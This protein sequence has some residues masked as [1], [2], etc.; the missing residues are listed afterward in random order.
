MS[1][2]DPIIITPDREFLVINALRYARG[3][4]TYVAEE[5]C[6]FVAHHWHQLSDKTKAVIARD[7][8]LELELRRNETA[9]MS[10]LHRIDTPHWEALLDTIEKEENND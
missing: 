8:R 4:A 10:A 3:R 7:V 5:M 1:Y 2:D 9:R 6:S